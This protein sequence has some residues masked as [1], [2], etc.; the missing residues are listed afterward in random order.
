MKNFIVKIFATDPVTWWYMFL[1]LVSTC[2]GST[3]YMMQQT[4]FKY[5]VNPIYPYWLSDNWLSIQTFW[6]PDRILIDIHIVQ[7][8]QN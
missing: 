7:F 6:N 5:T 3:V 1:K 4:S 8:A 2:W